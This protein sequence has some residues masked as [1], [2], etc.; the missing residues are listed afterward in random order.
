MNG[1]AQTGADAAKAVMALVSGSLP[2][3]ARL[4]SRRE[5]AR[6][7]RRHTLEGGRARARLPRCPP[8]DVCV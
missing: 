5:L 7:A 8:E 6:I 4:Y 2:K 1:G 3:A